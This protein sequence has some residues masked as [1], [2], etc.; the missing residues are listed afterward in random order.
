MR[1]LINLFIIKPQD[2]VNLIKE[3]NNTSISRERYIDLVKVISIFAVIYSTIVFLSLESS[4][5]EVLIY[6]SSSNDINMSIMSWCLNGLVVFFFC[7]GFSNSIAWYSNIGRDGSVWEF[8][9]NRIN[10]ILGPVLMLIVFGTI[11]IHY[12][13]SNKLIPEYL[14]TVNDNLHPTSEFLLWP[15][16]LVSI[17]L[18]VLMFSPITAYFH[19]KNSFLF[20]TALLTLFLFIDLFTFNQSIEYISYLNY[21]LFW[22]FVHQIGYFYADGTL[23]QIKMPFYFILSTVSYLTLYILSLETLATT[24][25]SNFRLSLITN[26]DPPTIFML[27]SGV[28]LISLVLIFR[29]L[30]EEAMNNKTLWYIVSFL[31]SHIYTIFLWHTFS[32]MFVYFFK[33]PL[34][35]L[36]LSF[37]LFFLI[38]GSPERN[39]FRLSSSLVKRISPEQPWPLPI[40]AR[41]SLN[42]VALS[43]YGSFLI[44]LS[45]VQITLGGVGTFGF[46]VDRQLFFLNGN[47]FEAFLRLIIGMVLLNIT[48]RSK[49]FRN[50]SLI[51][52]AIL[53]TVLLSYRLYYELSVHY[54]ELMFTIFGLF[55]CI[56]SIFQNRNNKM[57]K[58]VISK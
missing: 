6:N 25:V 29:N 8:L 39:T 55:L 5:Y 35:T 57:S 13:I 40:K 30:L 37:L 4:G 53:L 33:L 24:S 22:L 45:T 51:S 43:W 17:Y 16:W 36:V 20:I 10:S 1:S 9:A 50:I 49:Q 38:I 3:A 11:M 32:F 19:K 34:F 28:G 31:N 7:N 27:L 12:S 18:V 41:F 2:F 52:A 56:Y 21:L 46:L 42:N 58:R 44:L 47:T 48:I 26:E 14:V 54:L 23:Q 15:L